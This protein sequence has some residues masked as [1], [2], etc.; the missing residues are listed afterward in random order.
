MRTER[1]VTNCGFDVSGP[2]SFDSVPARPTSWV[3]V[4]RA[5]F[6]L[7]LTAV[8]TPI[9]SG[10]THNFCNEHPPHRSFQRYR[11][12]LQRRRGSTTSRKITSFSLPF[13]RSSV[14]FCWNARC[15]SRVRRNNDNHDAP[16]IAINITGN[17]CIGSRSFD[18]WVNRSWRSYRG[19]CTRCLI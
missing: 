15:T 18:L 13:H 9:L 3:D 7:V 5:P 8:K 4:Q 17:T 16:T 12:I 2:T 6:Y 14:V 19:C 1:S 11:P 10:H